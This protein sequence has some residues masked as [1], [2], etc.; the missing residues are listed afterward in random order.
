LIG[1]FAGKLP[2]GLAS[3]EEIDSPEELAIAFTVSSTLF[4]ILL[5]FVLRL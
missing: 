1:P 5:V 2:L 4:L 3:E